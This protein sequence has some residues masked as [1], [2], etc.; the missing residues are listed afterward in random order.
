M[1]GVTVKGSLTKPNYN[2]ESLAPPAASQSCSGS[3]RTVST[4][5]QGTG[6][7]LPEAIADLDRR[8]A[9][10]QAEREVLVTVLGR[11]TAAGSTASPG[12]A[13][14]ASR[15]AGEK[16]AWL[17]LNRMEAVARVLAEAD[18]PLSPKEITDLLHEHG[19]TD[20]KTNLVSA[21]LNYLVKKGRVHSEGRGNWRAG[22]P[23]VHIVEADDAIASLQM[24]GLT[25]LAEI[26]KSGG[27]A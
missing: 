3:I 21:A 18:R 14:I 25:E 24:Q 7:T 9:E 16:G 26:S 5:H 12:S 4:N 22:P 15:D 19:R 13:Q 8:I 2:D 17:I 1:A 20:D 6:P 11:M 10:M 27:A 23:T